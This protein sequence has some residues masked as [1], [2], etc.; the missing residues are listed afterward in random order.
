[1]AVAVVLG[2]KLLYYNLKTYADAKRFADRHVCGESFDA[3]VCWFC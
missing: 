2:V 1:M 3:P